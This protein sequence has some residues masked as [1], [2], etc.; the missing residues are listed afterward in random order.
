MELLKLLDIKELAAQMINFF[1]VFLL[2]KA[3][4]WKKILKALEDRRARIASE[5]KNIEEAK[6][7]AAALRA[8]YESRMRLAEDEGR[9]RIQSAV[10]KARLETETIRSHAQQEAQDIIENAKVSMHQELAAVRQELRKELV[11]LTILATENLI[12]EKL[13][14]DND[15]KIVEEFLKKAD[16]NT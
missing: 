14:E 3:F 9:R 7:Q 5:F 15:K 1:L 6:A 10:E 4:L 12:E 8:E 13:T 11:E 16:L 2:L